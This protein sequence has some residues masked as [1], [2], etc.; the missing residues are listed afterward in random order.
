MQHAST[1]ASRTTT[2][3]NG[4]KQ[5]IFR[6]S[7]Y[8]VD[9][10]FNDTFLPLKHSVCSDNCSKLSQGHQNES[11]IRTKSMQLQVAGKKV[12]SGLTLKVK[13]SRQGQPHRHDPTLKALSDLYVVQLCLLHCS[14]LQIRLRF[15][16]CTY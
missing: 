4:C 15:A 7:K 13:A 9:P 12:M 2:K 14:M 11:Q 10:N 6:R 16:L 3:S 5:W 8:V 1:P